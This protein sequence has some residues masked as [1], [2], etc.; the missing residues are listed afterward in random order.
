ME[1]DDIGG[2]G[3]KYTKFCMKSL[4]GRESLVHMCLYSHKHGGV[5]PK[6][7]TEYRCALIAGSLSG[8]ARFS[9]RAGAVVY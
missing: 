7:C 6:C 8:V 9:T 2:A 4:K 3:R 1:E 5:A